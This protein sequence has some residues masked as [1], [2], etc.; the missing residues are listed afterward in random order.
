MNGIEPAK[1][2]A[3]T[4]VE[5]RDQDRASAGAKLITLATAKSSE[6]RAKIVPIH[7]FNCRGIHKERHNVSAIAI[8]LSPTG[9]ANFFR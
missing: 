5:S 9:D 4:A 6:P 1:K 8:A 7:Q 3:L 2:M